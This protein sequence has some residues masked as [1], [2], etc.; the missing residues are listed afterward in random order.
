MVRRRPPGAATATA[1]V[2][3]HTVNAGGGAFDDL[4][5]LARPGETGRVDATDGGLTYDVTS[6]QVLSRERAGRAQAERSSVSRA[7]AVWC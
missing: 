7:A 1:V 4:E 2:T 6:V 3:G 5:T